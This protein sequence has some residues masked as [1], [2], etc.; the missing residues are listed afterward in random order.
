MMTRTMILPVLPGQLKSHPLILV[1]LGE[2]NHSV[3][4][5]KHQNIHVKYTKNEQGGRRKRVESLSKMFSNPA[6][7][8]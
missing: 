6:M 1:T 5:L 2:S 4:T 7:M 8:W 3:L